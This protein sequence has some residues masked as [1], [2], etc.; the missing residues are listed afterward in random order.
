MKAAYR[1]KS[2]KRKAALSTTWRR[3]I[4]KKKSSE[5]ENASGERM[6]KEGK[7]R[8]KRIF[9]ARAWKAYCARENQK[10]TFSA[11]RTAARTRRKSGAPHRKRAA[12]GY[13]A[14]IL[15]FIIARCAQASARSLVV[16]ALYAQKWN[17]R[18]HGNENQKAA[19]RIE[20]KSASK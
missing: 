11:A 19:S 5:N 4:M 9:A 17:E 1:R 18:N 2:E 15:R 10:N 6:L 3:K 8:V 12:C 7:W 16:G 14:S 13:R 20:N